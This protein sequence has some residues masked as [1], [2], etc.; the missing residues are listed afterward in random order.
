MIFPDQL[1]AKKSE[2]RQDS[3]PPSPMF[4]ASQVNKIIA[5]LIPYIDVSF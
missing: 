4:V 5:H 1:G 2:I 3:R